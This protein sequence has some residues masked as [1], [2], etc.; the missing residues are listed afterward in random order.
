MRVCVRACIASALPAF[1]NFP[2][3]V[4]S[5]V[6]FRSDS[7]QTNK[8]AN[9]QM[10]EWCAC[11]PAHRG[12]AGRRVNRPPGNG[13][14]QRP[15]SQTRTRMPART[16]T[17]THTHAQHARRFSPTS[18]KTISGAFPPN[19]SESFVRFGASCCN[20]KYQD[21][22]CNVQ[23]ANMR[24]G[25]RAFTISFPTAVEPVNET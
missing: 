19:S 6:S 9:K 22:T 4:A 3:T 20:I 15:H 17:N 16:H 21:E 8:Q 2:M 11:V 24:R 18:G 12:Y 14:M 10:A 13:A 5:A 23:H 1:R 25:A 7:K